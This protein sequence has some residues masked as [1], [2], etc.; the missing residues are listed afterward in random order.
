MYVTQTYL[1]MLLLINFTDISF[2]KLI[3]IFWII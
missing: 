1:H 3:A 2:T